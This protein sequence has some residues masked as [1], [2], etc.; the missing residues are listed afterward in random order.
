MANFGSGLVQGFQVGEAARARRVQEGRQAESDAW[1]RQDRALL[2]RQRALDEAASRAGAAAMGMG[3]GDLQQS[4]PEPIP[5]RAPEPVQDA[6]TVTPVRRPG[7]PVQPATPGAPALSLGLDSGPQRA[8][9]AMPGSGP[10]LQGPAPAGQAPQQAAP[11]MPRARTMDDLVAINRGLR[12]RSDVYAKGGDFNNALRYQIEG[13]KVREQLRQHAADQARTQYEAAGDV[14]AFIPFINDYVP[15]DLR[16][17]DIKQEGDGYLLEGQM[18][19]KPFQ[20]RMK[21]EDLRNFIG[22]AT[23]PDSARALEAKRA[24]E[25][26]KHRMAMDLE[27]QKNRFQKA[28]PGDTI[29]D[30]GTGR[31]FTGPAKP[32]FKTVK[33]ADGSESL[34]RVDGSGAQ[35]V[36]GGEEGGQS[37]PK[38]V[39]EMQKDVRSAVFSMNKL[40]QFASMTPEIQRMVGEQQ[41]LASN[42]IASNY[43]TDNWRGLS[44]GVAADIAARVQRGEI[45]VQQ[46]QV[47]GVEQPVRGVV[48]EGRKY[49]LDPFVGQQSWRPSAQPARSAAQPVSA[50]DFNATAEKVGLSGGQID[51]A[52]AI[53]AQESDSGR[54]DTT[55]P[56]NRSVRGPMQVKKETFDGMKRDGLIPADFDWSNPEHSTIAGL[57]LIKHLYQQYDGDPRKVAAAYY[58]GPKAVQADG[59]IRSFRDPDNPRMPDTFKYVDTVMRRMHG[60]SGQ[61]G[62][63]TNAVKGTVSQG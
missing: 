60:P 38:P 19:G 9:A 27:E 33:N 12:A 42:L 32:E 47:K 56:N 15:G 46:F 49:L 51:L 41:T 37:I 57:S 35:S 24:E 55:V 7:D 52:R 39:S 45:K 61:V 26:N 11:G 3:G 21:P 17:S 25:L 1:Q 31:T 22:F 63:G 62:L 34:V 18:A 36:Y 13:M 6:V 50:P 20:T 14:R 4:P 40:D 58:S 54:A 16:L 23:N 8:Q 28:G 10:A 59:S 53:F 48:F 30:T 29:V 5:M 2:E 44:A 43:G